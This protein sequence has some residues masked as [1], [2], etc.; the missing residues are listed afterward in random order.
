MTK[1]NKTKINRRTLL[2]TGGAI[3]SGSSLLSLASAQSTGNVSSKDGKYRVFRFA[4]M[5]DIHMDVKRNAE[6]GLA[7]ALNHCQNLD[8]P[9]DFIVT[10]GDNIMDAYGTELKYCQKQYDL[11][12]KTVKDNCSIPVKWCIGN[13]DVWGFDLKDSKTTG[14]E[15]L[16]GKKKPVA[17]YNM[18]GRYYHFD[19]SNW[20][21][22]ILDST[23]LNED[24][25]YSYLGRLDDEQKN[26]L[27][28]TLEHSKD[29]NI[30]VVSHIPIATVTILEETSA[31]NFQHRFSGGAMH[32]DSMEIRHLL[33]KYPNVKLCLSG[34]THRIDKVIW[35]GINYVCCGAVS[36]AWWKGNWGYTDE[37]YMVFD[38]YNNGEFDNQYISY[39]WKV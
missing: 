15:P 8:D 6:K 35:R 14:K 24:K 39:N 5:T 36:G 11:L 9:P 26:W 17:E 13:H 3:L 25:P 23:S 2:K 19:K 38:M 22:I 37:G 31:K 28:N 12:Q 10:G 27:I 29:K 34:H 18:Q 30:V 1:Q 20:R 21:F 7:S 33:E 32:Y 16:W 4:L